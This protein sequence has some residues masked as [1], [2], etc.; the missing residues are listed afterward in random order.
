M[1]SE[2]PPVS[3]PTPLPRTNH[4]RHRASLPALKDVRGGANLQTSSSTFDCSPFQQDKTNSVIKGLFTCAISQTNPNT[5]P[6]GATS[7]SGASS[8]GKS[9]AASFDPSAPLSGL[10]ALLAALLM[11]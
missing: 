3:L 9:S 1:T 10:G 2:R 7:G 5:N 8:T 6:N 4:H 11:I